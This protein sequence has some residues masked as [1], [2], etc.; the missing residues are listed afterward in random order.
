MHAELQKT[1][2]HRGRSMGR[3]VLDGIYTTAAVG[4]ALMAVAFVLVVV[5]HDILSALKDQIAEVELA[6]FAFRERSITLVLAVDYQVPSRAGP[7]LRHEGEQLVLLGAG[8]CCATVAIC[9]MV[10]RRARAGLDQ[11]V[12]PSSV[13]DENAACMK[14]ITS[15][16]QAI[17]EK[18]VELSNLDMSL[19]RVKDDLARSTKHLERNLDALRPRAAEA[20]RQPRPPHCAG[21]TC[22]QAAGVAPDVPLPAHG[23]AAGDQSAVPKVPTEPSRQSPPPKAGDHVGHEEGVDGWDLPS[24]T[25]DRFA[26][27]LG[28]RVMAAADIRLDAAPAAP[29]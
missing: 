28:F 9:A 24:P 25:L 22:V 8:F 13:A 19:A 11:N 20:P 4:T 1:P 7:L 23:I 3:P 14:T 6:H 15:L 2:P 12:G 26:S 29:R 10:A 21:E 18:E 16:Q 5:H 17:A 27:M